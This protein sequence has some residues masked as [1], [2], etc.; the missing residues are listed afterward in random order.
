MCSLVWRSIPVLW[1][2]TRSLTIERPVVDGGETP[3]GALFESEENVPPRNTREE[4]MSMRHLLT[5]KPF[6]IHC[7]ACNLGK[8]RK[9]KKFVGSYQESR[10]PKGWLDLVTADHLVA[11]NGSMEGI[12]GDFDA[13]VVKDLY[14]NVKVLLPV[15]NKT[16]EQAVRALRYIFG[17][18][19]VNRFYSDNAPELELA[20]TKLGIVHEKSR[21]GVPQNNS[22][23]ER[24]NLDILEGTRTTLVS[25]GFPECFW[26]F[27]A[28]RFCLL[29]NT[30]IIGIDGKVYK[31]GS[32]YHRAHGKGETTAL[33]IPFGCAVYFIPA[34]TKS[35]PK[36]K[37]EG[38]GE[39]GVI[40]GYN[41]SPG[42]TWG[43][44]YLCWSLKE[45]ANIN[46]MAKASKHPPG[47]QNPHVTK[48]AFLPG[49]LVTFLSRRSM[50]DSFGLLMAL[51]RS[52]ALF[53]VTSV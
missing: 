11:K 47:L 46:M 15:R 22:I 1:E 26:P 3:S 49:T 52:R 34:D 32:S 17:D 24:A 6:N 28:Q 50:T 5:H 2:L 14:S 53:R 44:E 48:F 23:F 13:L 42:Y 31:D 36:G 27:A 9:A 18:K 7:D 30:S 41:M 21:A 38:S 12:A 35:F 43:G 29:E 33:R 45:L 40:A 20:C 37:F 16:A 39:A 25:A 51:G 10:Q 4:A 19:V 8:M